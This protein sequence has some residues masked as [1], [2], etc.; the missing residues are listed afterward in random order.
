MVSCV[1]FASPYRSKK[2]VIEKMKMKKRLEITI[3]THEISTIR[4]SESRVITRFCETCRMTTLY[5]P[6]SGFAAK[7]GLSETAVFRLVETGRIHFVEG[8]SGIP[9]ICAN[10]PMR[11]ISHQSLIARTDL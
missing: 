1:Y 6:V 9:L 5:L 8:E 4:L 3:E 2:A 11:D 7:L 10:S